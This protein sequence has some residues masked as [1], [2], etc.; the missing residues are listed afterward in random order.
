MIRLHERVAG[1]TVEYIKGRLI[2][3][4]VTILSPPSAFLSFYSSHFHHPNTLSIFHNEVLSRRRCCRR[5][6]HLGYCRPC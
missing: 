3:L 4:H 2:P 5:Y 1:A 6:G